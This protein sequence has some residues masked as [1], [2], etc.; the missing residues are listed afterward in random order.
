MSCVDHRTGDHDTQD[1]ISDKEPSQ[2]NEAGLE[3]LDPQPGRRLP[4]AA[5]CCVHRTAN[6]D[7]DGTKCPIPPM[8][9]AH[10]SLLVRAPRHRSP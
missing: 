7:G 6:C 10:Q 5:I 9:G 4:T 1:G 3:V 2:P 8:S